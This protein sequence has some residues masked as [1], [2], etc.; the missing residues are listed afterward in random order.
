MPA[1]GRQEYTETGFSSGFRV[2]GCQEYTE[3]LK[4]LLIGGLAG[5][6][7]LHYI[8]IIPADFLLATSN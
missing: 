8:G 1:P 5:N 6:K 4:G 7:G 2:Q 3:I